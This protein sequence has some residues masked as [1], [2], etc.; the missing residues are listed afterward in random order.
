[1]AAGLL[2]SFTMAY[3]YQYDDVEKEGGTSASLDRN[4]LQQLIAPESQEHLLDPRAVHQVEKRLRGVGH[5]PRSAAETAEWLRRL[6]DLTPAELEGPMV[7]FLEE[8]QKDGRAMRLE[9]PGCKEP[10]RWISTEEAD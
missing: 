8:L 9:L 7:G 1:F 10:T 5:P 4:L 2:F 3:M 6:G